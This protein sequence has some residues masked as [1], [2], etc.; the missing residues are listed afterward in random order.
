MLLHH[1]T[2]KDSHSKLIKQVKEE[3]KTSCLFSFVYLSFSLFQHLI[4]QKVISF[5]F[6]FTLIYLLPLIDYY[7]T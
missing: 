3:V 4:F 5:D 2:S 1:K 6:N 7:G